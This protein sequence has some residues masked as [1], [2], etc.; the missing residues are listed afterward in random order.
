MTIR[1]RSIPRSWL[2]V[3]ITALLAGLAGGGYLVRQ[4]R[5][6]LHRDLIC[7]EHG[8][9][10]TYS[11]H[12]FPLSY[13]IL[14]RWLQS[15]G[16]RRRLAFH[17][18]QAQGEAYAYP[19]LRRQ[20]LNPE[21]GVGTLLQEQIQESYT[22]DP[23]QGVGTSHWPSLKIWGLEDREKALTLIRDALQ[24]LDV[25]QSWDH[26]NLEFLRILGRSEAFP[27][28]DLLWQELLQALETS[29]EPRVEILLNIFPYDLE[30]LPVEVV[31]RVQAQRDQQDQSW[32]ASL[33]E[34]VVA[35]EQLSNPDQVLAAYQAFDPGKRASVLRILSEPEIL[36]PKAQRLL[37]QVA[38]DSQ[39]PNHLWAGLLLLERDP[40]AETLVDEFAAGA[41]DRL[42]QYPDYDPESTQYEIASLLLRIQALFPD[43][44]L[45]QSFRDYATITGEPYFNPEFG[46]RWGW[47]QA[48]S[49]IVLS[50]PLS[51]EA[52]TALWQEWLASY[53]HHP[54]SDDATYWLS[55]SLEWQGKRAEGL[56]VLLD[57]L[58]NP[59]GDQHLHWAIRA[60]VFWLLDVGTT[61]ADLELLLSQQPDHALTP[62]LRYALAL[63]RARSHQYSQ[64]LDLTADLSLDQLLQEQKLLQPPNWITVAPL[65]PQLQEQRQRWQDLLPLED[66][67]SPKALLDLAERWGQAEGW[68]NGYFL[69]YNGW[70]A[71]SLASSFE[72]NFTNFMREDRPDHEII[73][74]GYQRANHNAVALDLLGQLLV[75]PTTPDE[76][77]EKAYYL[78]V[79][80]LS[81]QESLYPPS[82]SLAML[83]LP[84]FPADLDPNEPEWEHLKWFKRQAI[85]SKDQLFQAFPSSRY[86]D[87]VLFILT[88]MT[89]D[90]SYV[91]Q[92]VEAFPEGDLVQW[93]QQG[94]ACLQSE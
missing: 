33:E 2:W 55:R 71:A 29:P 11:D 94:Q 85:R 73:R 48:Q 46:G 7:L 18:L 78:Q 54:G 61:V 51:A 50:R 91:N 17:H 69:L 13:P 76:M 19:L 77:E 4:M 89:G 53:P 25:Q 1:P 70:R 16:P 44:R 5:A 22:F 83:P 64:A 34:E 62:L 68:R 39:D 88:D 90:D 38:L 65:D 12:W 59:T 6:D 45:A 35:L 37:E 28:K 32:G 79:V 47:D 43:S 82:E 56:Q 10:T 42:F 9:V 66:P 40:S 84:Y 20:L 23:V 74:T 27:H 30:S 60:R 41:F 87:D 81:R 93:W 26:F 31:T 21:A 52:E 92:A 67:Q 49:K 80:L 24:H 8:T 75:D 14:Q 58:V 86:G 15:E 57:W 3:G 36:S 63:Q 72:S